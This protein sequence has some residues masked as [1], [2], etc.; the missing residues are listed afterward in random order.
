MLAQMVVVV[1]GV[2]GEVD[3]FNQQLHQ[4]PGCHFEYHLSVKAAVWLTA[5]F[6]NQA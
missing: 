5:W 4:L 2:G 1:G 6:C 3:G